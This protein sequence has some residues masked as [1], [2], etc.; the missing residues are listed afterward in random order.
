MDEKP[1]YE[2]LRQR[3]KTLEK[4]IA[5]KAQTDDALDKSV[6]RYRAIVESSPMGIHFYELMKKEP[7]YAQR[8]GR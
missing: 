5:E 6:R 2:A 8:P 1:T 3:I 4:Q 7:R